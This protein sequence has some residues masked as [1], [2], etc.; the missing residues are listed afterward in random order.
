MAHLDIVGDGT[1]HMLAHE[2]PHGEH[3]RST[4][5]TGARRP[6]HVA[7]GPGPGGDGC[8]HRPIGDDVAL[9][10]DHGLSLSHR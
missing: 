3:A 4:V 6:A 5:A 10:D 7:Q 9:T 1:R 2:A 8:L